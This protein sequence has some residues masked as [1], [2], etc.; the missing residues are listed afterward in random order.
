MESI[1]F[2][3]VRSRSRP[4]SGK[5]RVKFFGRKRLGKDE[6]LN[7]VAARFPKKSKLF[8]RFHPLGDRDHGKFF[9]HFDDKADDRFVL[10]HILAFFQKLAV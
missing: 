7:H 2:L 5:G 4:L 8:L 3:Q 10:A 1:N 6:A 9:R